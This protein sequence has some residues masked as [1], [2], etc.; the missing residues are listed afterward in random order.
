MMESM[1]ALKKKAK[2]LEGEAILTV[3]SFAVSG[4]PENGAQ[5]QASPRSE[6]KP[7]KKESDEPESVGQ[8]IGKALGGGFGGFGGFG[9]KK[10]KEATPPPEPAPQ[11]DAAQSGPVNANL[12]TMTTELKSFSQAPIDI[13]LFDIPA[14][15]KVEKK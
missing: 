14:G 7:A 1:E 2:A 12:M 13:S 10:K 3:T 11:S 6:P 15:Y 4:T 5:P 9:R 8:A